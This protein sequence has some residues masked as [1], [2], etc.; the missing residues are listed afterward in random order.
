MSKEPTIPIHPKYGLN[1]TMVVCFWCGKET[2]EIAL[3]GA[4]YKAQAPMRMTVSYEPCE[5]CQKKWSQGFT[6]LEM[7]ETPNIEGQ[8]PIRPGIYPTGNFATF[9]WEAGER[10]FG[11]EQAEKGM[12]YISKE[13]FQKIV[14]ASKDL[15]TKDE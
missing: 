2:G 1:P 3:L 13:D 11:K 14:D 8:P 15:S 6:V 9:S 5:A 10:L 4:N 7:S 12:A